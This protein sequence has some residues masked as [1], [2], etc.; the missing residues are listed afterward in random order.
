[1]QLLD[2][3]DRLPVNISSVTNTTG[4]ILISRFHDS[5]H[6]TVD[7][8]SDALASH[9]NFVNISDSEPDNILTVGTSICSKCI[10]GISKRTF[11]MYSFAEKHS[12]L[13]N[14]KI[15]LL[16]LF[17]GGDKATSVGVSEIVEISHLV[18]LLFIKEF[19]V[20]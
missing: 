16:E 9:I 19:D 8:S 6:G 4:K 1:M 11:E 13:E 17:G 14:R 10:L 18:L 7:A 5:N 12:E 3:F 2:N 20:N 15:Y